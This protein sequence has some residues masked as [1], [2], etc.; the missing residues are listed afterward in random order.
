MTA[1]E[2]KSP[3][4]I[5]EIP[6]LTEATPLKNSTGEVAK[7]F[8]K[9]N[10]WQ[11]HPRN[12]Y[13]KIYR[14]CILCGDNRFDNE[15]WKDV[16]AGYCGSPVYCKKDRCHEV[17]FMIQ[18]F[19]PPYFLEVPLEKE[20]SEMNYDDHAKMAK[21]LEGRQFW[22]IWSIGSVKP[23]YEELEISNK[24]LSEALKKTLEALEKTQNLLKLALT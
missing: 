18:G 2:K 24:K 9:N 19:V 15:A 20:E 7:F 11:S 12:C 5:Y 13:I 17:S 10:P 23:T 22:S 21:E 1:I 3:T 4:P 6:N 14:F 8:F 16:T